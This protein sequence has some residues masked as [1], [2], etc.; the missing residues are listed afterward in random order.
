MKIL[1]ICNKS[2]YPPKE[3]GPMAMYAMTQLML[4][5]GCEVK[6]L[7]VNSPKCYVK[8]EDTD[9]EF[10]R[11]TDIEWCYIDTSLKVRSA[12][13][14]LLRN[15]SY[16]VERFIST[17]FEQK[18][19]ELLQQ[20]TF[21]LI[22]I[23]TIYLAVYLPAIRRYS[24][25]AV[26]LRAHNIEHM[27]WERV[28]RNCH[29]PFKKIYLRILSRQLKRF[30]DRALSA[31]DGILAISNVDEAYFRTRTTTPC[32]T[33]P[34]SLD[35]T[36]LP[37]PEGKD[38]VRT[39]DA[40]RTDASVRTDVSVRTDASAQTD[41]SARTNLFSIASMNWEPNI[42]GIQ[43]FLKRCWPRIRKNHPDLTFRIAGRQMPANWKSDP[44]Q[45]IEMV[46]E[47]PD[48]GTFMRENGILV[49][50]LLS[51]SGIR[52]K[53]IE[54]MSWGKTIV[55]TSIGTEGID[56]RH[57]QELY[58]ADSPEAFADAIDHCLS[59]PEACRRMGQTAAAF[60]RDHFD[61]TV[62]GAKLMQFYRTILQ[63]PEK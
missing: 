58:I 17:D 21:D 29:N 18:L 2:P 55:T 24:N 10:L 22:Q 62:V 54:G 20:E 41:V 53:I 30:E 46:G 38:A 33:S 50:P 59:H 39:N 5:A 15:R 4:Q 11:Q 13:S 12:L 60:I 63:T 8:A 23:E 16:H 49:V 56:T 37:M 61:A 14:A 51:G 28:A 42:E 34:Y 6:I 25:A 47:V 43:W 27:I 31:F 40:A 35:S 1:Q 32:V 9:N 44:S 45:G 7:A 3:G 57:G 52:I 26:L 36:S 48:A 19:K